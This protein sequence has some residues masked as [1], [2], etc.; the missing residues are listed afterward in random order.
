MG[1]RDHGGNGLFERRS[2]LI[3]TFRYHLRLVQ[4]SDAAWRRVEPLAPEFAPKD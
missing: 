3:R 1:P 4:P 2:P